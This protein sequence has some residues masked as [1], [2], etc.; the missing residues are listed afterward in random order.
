MQN[1]ANRWYPS[2]WFTRDYGFFSPTP[3]YWLEGDRL[4][5]PR[6]QV[7]ELKYRVVVHTGDVKQA[8]IA[9][10]FGQYKRTTGPKQN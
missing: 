6:G 10:K 7:L 8:R 2:K 1:P 4:E 5:L 9:R 3:M